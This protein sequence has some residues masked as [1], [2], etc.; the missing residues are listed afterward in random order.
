[1]IFHHG[2]PGGKGFWWWLF[3]TWHRETQSM[4]RNGLEL[5]FQKTDTPSTRWSFSLKKWQSIGVYTLEKPYP[6][7]DVNGISPW[8][9]PRPTKSKYMKPAGSTPFKP[10]Q[11]C[12]QFFATGIYNRITHLYVGALMCIYIHIIYIYC[13]HI[14]IMVLSLCV[15]IYW[16]IGILMIIVSIITIMII[17]LMIIVL[18]MII[19]VIVIGEA[20][21]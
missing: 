6:L 1:M 18:I 13:M 4:Y 14:V 20:K 2:G 16:Y 9:A 12:M 7:L 11:T 3:E 8:T 17:T 15:Y 10:L 21:S 5:D 19:I